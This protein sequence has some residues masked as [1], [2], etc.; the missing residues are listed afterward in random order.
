MSNKEGYDR[1]EK[2]INEILQS[3]TDADSHMKG[4]TVNLLDPKNFSASAEFTMEA[5]IDGDALAKLLGF[6]MAA[7]KNFT[8][9][10]SEPILVQA[11]RHKKK[12]IDKKWR[13]RY[14]Y[15]T[16][17]RKKQLTDCVVKCESSGDVL[18]VFGRQLMFEIWGDCHV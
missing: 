8:V 10:Y 17:F 1:L 14:G 5:E 11:R 18:S 13:K 16:I 6:P 7:G 3:S 4:K 15:K 9:E 2:K 12:R